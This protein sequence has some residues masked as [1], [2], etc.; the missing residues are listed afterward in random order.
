MRVREIRR[1]VRELCCH[2]K[3][4]QADLQTIR[5]IIQAQGYTIIEFDPYAAD[6]DLDLII[7]RLDLGDMI[8][9]RNGFTYAD[10]EYRLVFVNKELNENEKKIVLAHEMGHIVCGHLT[11]SPILGNSVI[12]EDEANQFAHYMIYLRTL[13]WLRISLVL[14]KKK[15]LA[16]VLLIC[17]V[18]SFVGYHMYNQKE[19]SYYGEFYVTENGEKY[20]KKGCAVIKDRTN[21]KRLTKKEYESGMYTPCQIC[22]PD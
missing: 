20:H 17:I 10:T 15:V 14:F 12:E 3:V 19:A 8:S 5:Q 21:I 11:H 1:L 22:L 4:R 18:G 16:A 2:Y 9:R 7:S 6:E 13:D